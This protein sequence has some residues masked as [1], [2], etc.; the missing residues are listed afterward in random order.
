MKELR[1]KLIAW[2]FH[3]SITPYAIVFKRKKQSWGLT[4]TDLLTYPKYS[5]G[6]ETGLFLT[7]NSFELMDRLE[8]HDTYHVITGYG[9]D[10]PNEIAQQYFLFGNGKRTTYVIGVLLLSILLLPD[11]IAQYLDAYKRGTASNPIH[12]LDMKSLL[13]TPVEDIK[14]FIFNHSP[15]KNHQIWQL[16]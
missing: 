14:S 5:L 10:V 9:T 12:H 3:I 11:N 1:E 7:T 15:L 2:L 6:H 4:A 16:S 13:N 8:A